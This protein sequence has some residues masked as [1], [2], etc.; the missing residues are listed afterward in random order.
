M[1]DSEFTKQLTWIVL[2]RVHHAVGYIGWMGRAFSSAMALTKK[3]LISQ[4][5][6]T[7]GSN[8]KT[9]LLFRFISFLQLIFVLLLGFEV[10][11]HFKKWGELPSKDAQLG[12]LNRVYI[13]WL[14]LRA[15]H[16]APLIRVISK[17]FIALSVIQCVDRIAL[18]LG[19][20]GIR[21]WRVKPRLDDDLSGYV[22]PM[23]LVQIPMCN[24]REVYEHSISAACQ[25]DWPKHSFVI[26]VLDDS[27]DES[28]QLLIQQRVSWWRQEGNN[29]IYHHR[30]VRNGYKAGN[31]KSGMDYEY[32]KSCE[33]VVIF[34]SDF[35]PKPDFLK[36]T[37]PFFKNDP[38][39]GLVQARWTLLN[40]DENLL[41][42][43]Q[44]INMCSHFELEQQVNGV[45]FNFFGFNG[46]A[47]VWRIK[48]LEDSGG[49]LERTTV[50]D[51]DI[52]VRAHVKGWKFIFLNDVKVVSCEVPE[53]YDA[54]RKQQHR[55]HSGPVRLFCLCLPDILSSKIALWKKANLILF[56]LLRKLILPLCSFTLVCIILPLT[57]FVPEA[58]LPLWLLYY[59]PVT[60]SFLNS[61]PTPKS[62]HFAIPYLLFE[63]TMSVAKFDAVV[64][65][66]FGS[67]Y[68]W[69][70]T[71]KAGR[72]SEM[73]KRK[74]AKLGS[75]DLEKH[76]KEQKGVAGQSA[77]RVNC[78][79][80]EE[81]AIAFLL[82]IASVRSL[83]SKEALHFCFLFSQGITFLVVGLDLISE[84]IS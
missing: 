38:D 79:F 7:Q 82:L 25:L 48:A 28:I 75:D 36:K 39:L 67:S 35:L 43:L 1:E 83:L 52:A 20:L 11:A 9:G 64:S 40:K 26:Q 78:I 6:E 2:L 47:G 60:M 23:V 63:N 80:K 73:K 14:A 66:L 69:V 10:L 12:F 27:D 17:L 56:F 74:E 84:Q 76:L 61:L 37:V 65:G 50:E 22:H 4:S 21:C 32:A 30:A 33:F 53:L 58:S 55:W 54:Y 19:W 71:K 24:E 57:M 5:Q 15:E 3:R 72:A 44:N 18:F 42:R 51:M 16:I 68:E 70:V 46:T 45:F 34:D 49:W 77:K 59:L 81:L 8:S 29:I 62:S 41:T 31:L 13:A